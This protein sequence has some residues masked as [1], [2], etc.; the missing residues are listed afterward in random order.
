MQ[1][2]G[3]PN[4]YHAELEFLGSLLRDPQE[5]MARVVGDCLLRPEDLYTPEHALIAQA[6]FA[7]DREGRVISPTAIASWLDDRRLLEQAGG[8]AYIEELPQHGGVLADAAERIVRKAMRRD[9]MAMGAYLQTLAAN[10]NVT[11]DDIL[12]DAEA[13]LYNIRQRRAD[14]VPDLAEIAEA[15]RA[16]IERRRAGVMTDVLRTNIPVL[17]DH[18]GDL[19]RNDYMLIGGRPGDGKSTWLRWILYNVAIA[20]P[21]EE[22]RAVYIANFEEGAAVFM[23]KLVAIV[24]GFSTRLLRT[25]NLMSDRQMEQVVSAIEQIKTAPVFVDCRSGMT[26]AAYKARVRDA[27]RRARHDFGVEL[28]FHA[29][30][31]AQRM[32]GEGGSTV[33][34]NTNISNALRDMCAVDQLNAPCIGTVQ[35]NRESVSTPREYRL[36]DIKESSAYEQDATIAAFIS[37]PW[38]LRPPTEETLRRFAENVDAQNRLIPEW[39]VEPVRI[40][41]AKN[42]NGGSGMSRYVLWH[43][44]S[45]RFEED[46]RVE[47]V[48]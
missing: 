29:P 45:G 15:Y 41:V 3:L 17:D 30:D 10:E 14:R 25:P 46:E 13:S 40:N 33:E 48:V 36:A 4:D 8:L 9:A 22:R 16:R 12:D 11:I 7:L 1:T 28:A 43:R 42:R 18:L 23:M 31:Y 5:A 44:Y 20:P 34:K 24:T 47:A 35:L 37:R 19:E 38:V 21:V 6:A 39:Q 2:A 27:Q 32:R 26:P